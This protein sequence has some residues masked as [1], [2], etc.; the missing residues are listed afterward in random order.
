MYLLYK[1]TVS[2]MNIIK[3]IIE[4]TFIIAGFFAAKIISAFM[5]KL[6]SSQHKHQS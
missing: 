3:E 5:L 6:S 4:E 1:I 2:G